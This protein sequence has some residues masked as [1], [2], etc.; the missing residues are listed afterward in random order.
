MLYQLS[1]AG[2]VRRRSLSNTR[3]RDNPRTSPYIE[4]LS[5]PASIDNRAATLTN[6]RDLMASEY[7]S[8]ALGGTSSASD[9]MEVIGLDIHAAMKHDS[10]F[11]FIE[12]IVALV[13]ASILVA[14]AVPHYQDMAERNRL[15]SATNDFVGAL[16]LARSTAVTQGQTVN[17]CQS[18]ASVSPRT[19]TNNAQWDLGYMLWIDGNG[20]VG[21][22]AGSADELIQTWPGL[23]EN[24]RLQEDPNGIGSLS[25][26]PSGRLGGGN[27]PLNFY[28]EPDN[29]SSNE[30]RQIEITGAGRP[31]SQGDQACTL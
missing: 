19:C 21:F 5:P 10:G 4:H 27:P 22:Q 31:N 1:Y 26:V 12:L 24:V 3:E 14:M 13:V 2:D 29:C 8:S 6:T 7:R 25:Y 11:T 20:T 18:D 15:T 17:L 9:F 23:P 16:N 30:A 28:V